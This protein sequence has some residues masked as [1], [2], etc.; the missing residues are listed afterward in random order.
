[1]TI[2]KVRVVS[3]SIPVNATDSPTTVPMADTTPPNINPHSMSAARIWKPDDLALMT[4]SDSY[5][6][7]GISL[8]PNDNVVVRDKSRDLPRMARSRRETTE[9]TLLAV[10]CNP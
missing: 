10:D 5:I 7:Y 9:R 2:K 3:Q 1:M 4:G 8:Y 6:A